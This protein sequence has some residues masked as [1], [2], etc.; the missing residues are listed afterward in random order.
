[1][2]EGTGICASNKHNLAH[3]RIERRVGMLV[4]LV[5]IGGEACLAYASLVPVQESF[6]CF[7]VGIGRTLN[8]GVDLVRSRLDWGVDVSREGG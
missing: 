2:N 5:A 4:R 3:T 7:V 6:P 8:N 1:M